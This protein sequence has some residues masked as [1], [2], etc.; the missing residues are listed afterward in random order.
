MISD[1]I[2]VIANF[3]YDIQIKD[4]D[5]VTYS[6][7]EATKDIIFYADN[8]KATT[9]AKDIVVNFVPEEEN[10]ETQSWTL[11]WNGFTPT[12]EFYRYK[13]EGDIQSELIPVTDVVEFVKS[14]GKTQV[15]LVVK[16]NVPWTLL[17]ELDN[18]IIGEVSNVEQGK[19]LDR[20][21]TNS[22]T[23]FPVFNEQK[24]DSEDKSATLSFGYENADKKQLT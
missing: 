10:V 19:N 4:V 13:V 20:I 18:T 21:F 23:I 3:D 1:R 12:V 16:S 2:S 11:K 14:E 6:I 7:D 17:T 8:E 5:W 15:S 22:L 24:L 9:E